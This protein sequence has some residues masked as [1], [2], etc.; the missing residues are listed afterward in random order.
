MANRE[1][2][3]LRDNGRK[4]KKSQNQRDRKGKRNRDVVVFCRHRTRPRSRPRSM[5]HD[6]SQERSRD[7]SRPREREA[8][9]GSSGVNG[10]SPAPTMG[11]GGGGR[12]WMWASRGAKGGVVMFGWLSSSRRGFLR[13]KD[14]VERGQRG[15][16]TV[17]PSSPRALTVGT[18]VDAGSSPHPSM[19][20]AQNSATPAL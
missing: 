8:G 20:S 19:A 7:L 11:E 17:V 14:T 5:L 10:A 4:S 3:G 13:P 18:T 15:N 16:G 1:Q 6:R 12:G 2:R 9:E